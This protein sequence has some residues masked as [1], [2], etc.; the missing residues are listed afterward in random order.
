MSGLCV[1]SP[2]MMWAG[3]TFNGEVLIYKLCEDQFLCDCKETD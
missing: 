1:C 3:A 2:I